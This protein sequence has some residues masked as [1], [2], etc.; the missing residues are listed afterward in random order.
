MSGVTVTRV[1][2]PTEHENQ[3]WYVLRGSV[4]GVPS[5]TKTTSIAMAAIVARPAILD[6]ARAKLI[7]DVTEYHANYLALKGLP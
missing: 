6:E 5:V 7:A 3:K 2:L 1:M 4:E